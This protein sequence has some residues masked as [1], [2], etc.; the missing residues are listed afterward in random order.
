MDLLWFLKKERKN[1]EI[2]PVFDDLENR[3]EQELV[4][5]YKIEEWILKDKAN[6]TMGKLLESDYEEL[7][8]IENAII[9]RIPDEF[10]KE[11]FRIFAKYRFNIVELLENDHWKEDMKTT[12]E[13]ICIFLHYGTP[14]PQ[15]ST[16]NPLPFPGN[17][18]LLWLLS[19]AGEDPKDRKS[20]IF[21][22]AKPMFNEKKILGYDFN[23]TELQSIANRLLVIF[24]GEYSKQTSVMIEI[25]LTVE[26]GKEYLERIIKETGKDIER[27]STPLK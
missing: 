21:D 1:K 3:S 6:K 24:I 22:A 17:E 7:E 25:W 4:Q 11:V 23:E 8:K 26:G 27:L 2:E 14:Y 10:K 15:I 19:K 13:D 12:C 20:S 5:K 18:Y 9:K 16:A